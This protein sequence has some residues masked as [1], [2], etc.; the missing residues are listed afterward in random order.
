[1]EQPLTLDFHRLDRLIISLKG[2][3]TGFYSGQRLT[4]KYGTALEFADYRPYLPGDDIRRIDWLLYGRSARLYTKL[5]RSEVDATV[6]FLIDGSGSLNWGEPHK[7]WRAL[8][9]TLALSYISLQSYDRVAVG[10]GCKDLGAY[11]PPLYG[12]GAFPRVKQFL[13]RQEFHAEGD[14]NRLLGSFQKVLKP[15]QMTVLLSDFLSPGGYQAGLE[16]LLAARQELLVIQII[17]PDELEPGYAG[18]VALLDVETNRKK[19]VIVDP[20]LRQR[21]REAVQCYRQEIADF[22]SRR[23]IN[24]LLYNT[25]QE[26]VEFLLGNAQRLFQPML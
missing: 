18:P 20:Y 5:N 6:N 26:P 14:L 3:L 22:C 1:M 21:Y 17:S 24:Y 8:Q 7:G 11:L 19:E 15:R 13:Q 16:R 10:L 2:G 25:G 4:N 12:K 9:L 23:K